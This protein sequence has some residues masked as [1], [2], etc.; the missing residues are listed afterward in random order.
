MLVID[1]IPKDQSS[2]SVQI[3][4]NGERI[5]AYGAYY[6]YHMLNNNNNI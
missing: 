5:E 3:P 2:S 4:K 6:Y 1:I